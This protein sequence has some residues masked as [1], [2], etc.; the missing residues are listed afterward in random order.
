VPGAEREAWLRACWPSQTE[1]AAEAGGAGA[2]GRS[3]AMLPV[4]RRIELLAAPLR[5]T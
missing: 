1:T 5:S 4:L 3:P 2:D